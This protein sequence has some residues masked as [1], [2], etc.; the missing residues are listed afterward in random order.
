MKKKQI[1]IKKPA[2]GF[3][4]ETE[5]DMNFMNYLMNKYFKDSIRTFTSRTGSKSSLMASSIVSVVNFRR[6]DYDHVIIPFNV[7]DEDKDD[8]LGML[9]RR[10]NEFGM[11]DFVTL[12]PIEPSMRAWMPESQS[13]E[14]LNIEVL[15][16]ENPSFNQLL[17]QIEEFANKITP[18]VKNDKSLTAH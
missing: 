8:L 6:H 17:T 15:R 16:I 14:D 11:R 18:S 12:L 7:D 10:M 2:L 4:V 5:S 13:L 9:D 1:E 3:V